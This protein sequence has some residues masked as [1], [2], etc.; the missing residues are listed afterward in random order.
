[1]SWKSNMSNSAHF[2][3]PALTLLAFIGLCLEIL[4]ASLEKHLYGT[5][6][7]GFSEMQYIRHW[8]IT[9]ALWAI[10]SFWAVFLSKRLFEFNVFES[11]TVSSRLQLVLGL[12]LPLVFAVVWSI[13]NGGPGIVR[14]YK[15]SSIAMFIW[16]Y[17]YYVFEM[18]LAG[19]IICLSQRSFDS[20]TGK[21]SQ[22]PWGGLM[23]GLS[24]GLLHYFT[25]SSAVVAAIAFILAI[26]FGMVFNWLGKDLKK[27]LPLMYLM[28]VCL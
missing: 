10:V 6:I 21:P 22:I 27:T 14:F 15:N 11:H 20:R 5:D 23:L 8:L 7:A 9:S 4:L 18:L 24:W 28:F 3:V 26:L 13:L 1:M 19:L 17:I 16:Q 25:K 2:K 12:S